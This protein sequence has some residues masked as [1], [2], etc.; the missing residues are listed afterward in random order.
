M[1]IPFGTQSYQHTSLPLSAQR[2]VNCY[3]EPAP[4]HAKTFAAVIASY[5]VPTV[6]TVGDGPL[7][8]AKLVRNTLYVVSGTGLYRVNSAFVATRLGAIPGAGDVFI[9]GDERNVMVVEPASERGWYW[10]GTTVAQ[11]TDSD[12]PGAVWLGYLD[13]YFL[14]IAPRSGTFYITGNRDPGSVDALDFASD[15]RY[16]DDLV[17]GI[18]DHGE[19]IL[20]GTESFGGFYDSGNADFPISRIPSADGEFGCLCPWGVA[21]KDNSVFFPASD[22]KVYRLNGYAPQV[23]SNP[24]IEKAIAEAA[25]RNFRAII[26][27]EPGHSF[28]GL[29]CADF[30]FI[31]DISTGLWYERE[32]HGKSAWRWKFAVRA[33]ERWVI[34]DAL[35]NAIGTL[36]A[37]TF[38]EFGDVLRA[39]GTSPAVGK[40]NMRTVHNVVELVF[41][42]G[43]GTITGQGRNPKCMLQFSDDG[44]RHWSNEK[45]RSIGRWG[46][47]GARSRWF[48]LGSA[49]DRVYRYAFSDPVRRNLILATTKAK[50]RA[51]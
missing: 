12:W 1:Q 51:A 21:K 29:T 45:W 36:S 50:L 28:Y 18:V 34:G 14:I 30:A 46:E 6:G 11:V 4:P 19:L 9:E 39:E 5:G 32:S 44:G 7:R 49:R 15:E 10:N 3:L 41:E 23:I 17:T 43:T 38:T 48:R 37:D 2:M 42:Q 40:E 16:P 22:G 13:G 27:D 8:G 20:F 24:V 33:Y 35:S 25:D 47:T 26:W 31:Y